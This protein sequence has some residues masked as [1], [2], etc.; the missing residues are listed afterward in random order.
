MQVSFLTSGGYSAIYRGGGECGVAKT[1]CVLKFL[2]W[3][4]QD[5]STMGLFG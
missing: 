3:D 4:Y 2:A 1:F 5:F